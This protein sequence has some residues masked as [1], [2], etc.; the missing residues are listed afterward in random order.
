MT[1]TLIIGFI[2]FMALFITAVSIVFIVLMD[3]ATNYLSDDDVWC[4]ECNNFKN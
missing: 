2:V 1:T 3:S 4:E